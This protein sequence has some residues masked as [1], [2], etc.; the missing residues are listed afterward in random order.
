MNK[1]IF[2]KKDGSVL[3]IV[4][5]SDDNI[6]S[7]EKCAINSNLSEDDIVMYFTKDEDL[8]SITEEDKLDTITKIEDKLLPEKNL[9]TLEER[10][11]RL[12]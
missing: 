4:S 11:Q 1:V 9:E 10:K 3:S 12:V 7:K 8:Q 6:P 5:I 2:S